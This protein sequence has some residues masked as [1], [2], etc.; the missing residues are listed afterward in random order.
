[1]W[2]PGKCSGRVSSRRC[3]AVRG[4][5][6]VLKLTFSDFGERL[7]SWW[8]RTPRT[9][10]GTTPDHEMSRKVLWADVLG[11]VGIVLGTF[12]GPVPRSHSCLLALSLPWHTYL[13]C[14]ST[15]VGV[16]NLKTRV[17]TRTAGV[18]HSPALFRDPSQHPRHP[19]SISL[20]GHEARS[21][22]R[23]R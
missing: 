22:T 6:F 21:S 15:A 17:A 2:V 23:A 8:Q 5:R 12:C 14:T 10:W 1:M 13:L 20:S 11:S 16:T 3:H 9:V 4:N 7:F 18:Q 19:S